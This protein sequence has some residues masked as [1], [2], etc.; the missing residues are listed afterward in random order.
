MEEKYKVEGEEEW[1]EEVN[2]EVEEETVGKEVS[3]LTEGSTSLGAARTP[4]L[5]TA[6]SPRRRSSRGATWR[7]LV[8][9]IHAK[10]IL[11]LEKEPILECVHKEVEQCHYTYVTQFKPSQEEVPS[12]SK[13]TVQKLNQQILA[14]FIPILTLIPIQML[15]QLLAKL[16]TQVLTSIEAIKLL[17]PGVRE[18]ILV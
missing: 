4:T 3:A 18:N 17:N 5:A 11:S 2:E 8:I 14:K 10:F 7:I 1:V 15:T 9:P 13:N 12:Y 6:A 16:L